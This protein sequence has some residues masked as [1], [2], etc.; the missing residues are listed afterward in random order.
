M[1]FPTAPSIP[2]A[3]IR[4]ASHPAYGYFSPTPEYYDAIIRWQKERNGVDGVL[5]EHIGYENG[6]LGGVISAADRLCGP[7]ATGVAAAQPDLYRLYRLHHQQRLQ[8][9]SFAA[10]P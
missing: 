3:I 10:V 9:R 2:E 6:V 8:D 4:R 7:P 5:P 1:N